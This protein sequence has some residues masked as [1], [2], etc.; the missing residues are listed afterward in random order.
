MKK[1]IIVIVFGFLIAILISF[2]YLLWDREKQLESFQDMSDSKN[3]TIDTLSEKMNNLDK[4]NKELINKNGQLTQENIELKNDVSKLGTDNAELMQKIFQKDDLLAILRRNMDN[5][6]V[7]ELLK[8][9]AED[10]SSKKYT[11]AFRLISKKT[12]NTLLGSEET[13]KETYQKEVKS[14]SIKSLEPYTELTDEEH[15]SK[16][17]FKVIFDVD[18]PEEAQSKLFRSGNNEKYV[19]VDYDLNSKE[20]KI[21]DIEDKP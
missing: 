14:I 6:P 3:L 13:L 5:E 4:Q 21:L 18:K 7:N 17:Q 20:W 19:S 11:E 8:A 9:W 12:T 1:F 10:I 16:I 15:M 2:N